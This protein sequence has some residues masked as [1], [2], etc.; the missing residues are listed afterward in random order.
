[1]EKNAI[2]ILFALIFLLPINGFSQKIELKD[3]SNLMSL[4]YYNVDNMLS[5]SVF[6]S[7]QLFT[8]KPKHANYKLNAVDWIEYEY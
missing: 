5:Q 8:T 6:N 1:M 2:K 4:P 7:D 3:N